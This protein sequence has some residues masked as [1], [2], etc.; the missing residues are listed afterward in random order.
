MQ[1]RALSRLRHLE[2]AMPPIF[3]PVSREERRREPLGRF[4]PI[5]SLAQIGRAALLFFALCAFA[6]MIAA[7]VPAR[8]TEQPNNA[9]F[10]AFLAQLWPDAQARGVSRQ[11]FDAAFRGVTL[12]PKLLAHTKKQAE[13]VKPIWDYLASSISNDRITRGRARAAEYSAVLT[14]SESRYGVDPYVVA[15]VWGLESSF[16]SFTGG[17]YAIRALAT[18]AFARYRGDFFREELLE[19]LQILQQGH[20]TPAAMGGSWA[21][22]MGQTQFMPSSFLKYAVD[23]DNDGRKDIW[24]DIP[25]ALAS[26]ANYLK[27]HGWVRGYTWGY[28]VILP[29]GYDVSPHDPL[30]FRGFAQWAAEG[31]RRADGEPMPSGGEAT[32]YLAAGAKGPAFLLTQNFRVIKSYNNSTYYALAVGIL[33]DRIAGGG[34]LKGSWP[35]Q[36]KLLSM[37]QTQELQRHLARLG[38][39]VGEADGRIGDKAQTAIRAYQRKLGVMADGY[40]TVALLERVRKGQ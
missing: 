31:V 5:N 30:K 34:G 19:A 38:F 2:G 21:G 24:N 6:L 39:D 36:D 18:L 11:T 14:A 23:Y 3:H 12:N 37:V 8:A 27:E 1:I 35:K 15:A 29:A 33:S 20:T 25:D 26:T 7:R 32:L 28:E 22:A 13:F 9:A 40:P 17:E 10:A 4:A 16:G